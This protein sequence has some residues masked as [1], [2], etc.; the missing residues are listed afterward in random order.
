MEVD[1]FYA[2]PGLGWRGSFIMTSFNLEFAILAWRK[3]YA[4][5][6]TFQETDLDELERHVRDQVEYS[7]SIGV[8]EEAA[9]RKSVAELGTVF[10]AET[11]F[12]KVFWKKLR[13]RG[14]FTGEIRWRLALAGRYIHTG[15]RSLIKQ[16]VVS[17]INIFGL[18]IALAASICV[19]I[20]LDSYLA[21]DRFHEN[22][23]RIY[24]VGHSIQ[25]EGETERWGMSPLALGPALTDQVAGVEDVVRVDWQSGRV[26]VAGKPHD[27]SVMFVEDGY[28]DMMTFPIAAGDPTPLDF[29]NGI[30]ITP[31][32]V[33]RYFGD[34][35]PLGQTLSFSLGGIDQLEFTVR[36]VLE[37]LPGASGMRFELLAS[38]ESL[39]SL[40]QFD[41]D[42]W[43]TRINGTLV[44]LDKEANPASVESF[45]TTLIPRQNIADEAW[46]IDSFFLDN[47]RNP[48]EK[49]YLIKN[50]MLEASHPF[51]ILILVLIPAAMM[52]LSIFNYVN[53]AIGSAERRLR[54][55]GIRKVVGGTRSQLITQ[56]LVENLVLVSIALIV[57]GF[58]SWL[59]LL[60]M[61]DTIFVYT[62]TWEP[63]TEVAFWGSMLTLLL[64]T[65]L[66]SGAY[67]ALY[68]SSFKPVTVF[69]GAAALPGRRLLAHV[70]LA[71]Q[72]TVAFMAILLGLFMAMGNDFHAQDNWGY[73]SDN[74]VTVALSSDEQFSVLQ[75]KLKGRADVETVASAYH[76]IGLSQSGR[77]ITYEDQEESVTQL[78]V[79]AGYFNAMGLPIEAGRG[80][81]EAFAS[82]DNRAV[83][84]SRYMVNKLDWKDPIGMQFRSE[85]VDY[86]V[87][88]ISSDP[89]I[90]PIIRYRPLFFSRIP[91]SMATMAV[92]RA[93]YSLNGDMPSFVETGWDQLFPD[94]PFDGQLQSAVFDEHFASWKNLTNAILWLAGLALIISCM[95]LFGLASQGVSAKMKEIC[96]RKVL[97]ANAGIVAF[98]VHLRYLVLIT[99]GAA[100]AMPLF[101]LGLTIPIKTF[102]LDY[103]T[104]GPG[105]FVVSYI[106]VIAVAL[107]SIV[108]HAV[109]LARV[110]PAVTLRGD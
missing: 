104:V 87:V 9:F 107:L 58:I 39:A 95:G 72:F 82:D 25:R 75:S 90:H 89:I 38:F 24:M 106:L 56:F 26:L 94:R 76:H 51:L 101:Y 77:I 110:N 46:Q 65:A 100:I 66:V 36:S 17:F 21:I 32:A 91:D 33:E 29:P 103:I 22:G 37:P 15:Y 16:K 61:F 42:D 93:S 81:D 2:Y 8:E 27:G 40:R 13:H 85:G 47:L 68:I 23:D 92:I 97:G 63:I 60:P 69:R 62:L 19:Y 10:E 50:R 54:E 44:L 88:G 41:D 18:S 79:G 30:A 59:F 11:E 73:E 20:F 3:Q 49:A 14:Q 4:T 109:V 98:R 48:V 52:L 31:R 74:V 84:V 70:F 80:F 57:A 96:I 43:E 5:N 83:V 35:N 55:I 6:H 12:R 102:D 45:L 108:R 71:S 28:L 105:V 78:K 1:V 86:E 67:P 34:A 7:V 53:I 64:G 99:I